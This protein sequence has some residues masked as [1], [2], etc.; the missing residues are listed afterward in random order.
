VQSLITT[1]DILFKL[2]LLTGISLAPI[3]GRSR[4]QSI[5]SNSPSEASRTWV[6]EWKSKISFS[7]RPGKQ[8]KPIELEALVEEKRIFE[9]IS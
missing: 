8:E 6:K 2:V 7:H 4:L 3:L 5:I 9:D 1:P